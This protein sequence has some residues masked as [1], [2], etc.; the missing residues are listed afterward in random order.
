MLDGQRDRQAPG[1][2][3]EVGETSQLESSSLP[4]MPTK[5]MTPSAVIAASMTRRIIDAPLLAKD[6]PLPTPAEFAI[7]SYEEKMIRI[8][9]LVKGLNTIILGKNNL[10]KTVIKYS[11][12][13]EQAI[14]ALKKTKQ[15]QVPPRPPFAD[16]AVC[17]SPIF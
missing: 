5:T 17:T 8:E 14:L 10:H 7:G 12:S 15:K 6:A 9:G 1:S 3:D 2:T 4:S 13:L 16:K 11:L